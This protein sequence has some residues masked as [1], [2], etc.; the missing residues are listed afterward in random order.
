MAATSF[1]KIVCLVLLIADIL[2]FMFRAW[3]NPANFMYYLCR[4]LFEI[5]HGSSIGM[6]IGFLIRLVELV[7][8][9]YLIARLIG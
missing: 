3:G 2:Y 7:T 9:G 8:I 6:M 5:V 1:L 4:P